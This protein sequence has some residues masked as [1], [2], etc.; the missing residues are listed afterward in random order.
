IR[1]RSPRPIP[2]STKAAP[3]IRPT[4]IPTHVAGTHSHETKC[5][6]ANHSAAPTITPAIRPSTS[7]DPTESTPST[8]KSAR[9]PPIGKP[10]RTAIGQSH[11]LRA[12][13]FA[14]LLCPSTVRHPSHRNIQS[15]PSDT[16]PLLSPASARSAIPLDRDTGLRNPPL[17][18]ATASSTI[19]DRE[20]R[21]WAPWHRGQSA[22]TRG[23]PVPQGVGPRRVGL[24]PPGSS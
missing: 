11:N 15:P 18:A 22:P 6:S 16:T 17:A 20:T 2:Y 13:L 23:L 12:G 5:R 19:R 3:A 24:P 21:L 7:A 10:R 14:A 9:Y 8:A 4:A 1:A